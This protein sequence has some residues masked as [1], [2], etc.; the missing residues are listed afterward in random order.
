[1]MAST[2]F[3]ATL[4]IFDAHTLCSTE[5]RLK[6]AVRAYLQDNLSVGADSTTC[7]G[8]ALQI[9]RTPRGKPYLPCDP[10][11]HISA[12]HSGDY[13]ICAVSNT[14]IGIDIQEHS[15]LKDETPAETRIRLR[16]LANRF[17]H[18]EEAEYI[19]PHPDQHFFKVWTAKESYVK[20]TGQGIDDHFADFSVLPPNCTTLPDTDSIGIHAHWS[21]LDVS[22]YQFKLTQQYTVCICTENPAE[23]RICR[24]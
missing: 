18:P 6:E 14:A 3:H 20:Y 10:N 11:I 9:H 16:K 1:M 17:L 21:A 13:L 24:L 5:D 8:S 22:F 15:T 23:I 7:S 2:P 19:A 4:Y 12:S